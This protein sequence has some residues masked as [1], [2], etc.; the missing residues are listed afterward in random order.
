MTV[1]EAHQNSDVIFRNFL[2]NYISARVLFDGGVSKSFV[3][4]PF[5]LNL[6]YLIVI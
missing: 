3:S 4:I 1:E 5:V 6:I 2:V